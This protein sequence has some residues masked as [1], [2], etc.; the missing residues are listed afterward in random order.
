MYLTKRQKDILEFLKEYID[1]HGYAPSI[2]EI[3]N[4][5]DSLGP[6]S[7]SRHLD[8]LD[9][10]GF[11]RKDPKR[12][13][14]ITLIESPSGKIDVSDV[15]ILGVFAD[16]SSIETLNR[17]E[18]IKVS[19]RLT[20]GKHVYSLRVKGNT[21]EDVHIIEGDYLIIEARNQVED[22]EMAIIL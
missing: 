21:L 9:K 22:G 15:P 19:P 18:F 10:K 6:A 16:G 3:S 1:K 17:L 4:N 11:I 8:N 14:S 2:K 13:R 7:I 12:S 5:F 20:T